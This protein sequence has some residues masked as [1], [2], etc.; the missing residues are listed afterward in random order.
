M[1][2]PESTHGARM[3]HTWGTYGAHIRYRSRCE[4]KYLSRVGCFVALSLACQCSDHSRTTWACPDEVPRSC[5]M[6]DIGLSFS[7][8]AH[9]V[10]SH[11]A[12]SQRL[13]GCHRLM[14]PMRFLPAL[15]PLSMDRA[16]A[17]MKWRGGALI[18]WSREASARMRQ[19]E[20]G[21]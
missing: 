20:I 6:C 2:S 5:S 15:L 11:T 18:V 8:I 12:Q 4:G 10:R 9:L 16:D 21:L 19:W 7:H 14:P 1:Q 3:E 13:L 17:A